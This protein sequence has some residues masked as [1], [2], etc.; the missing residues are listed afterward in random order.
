MDVAMMTMFNSEERH[1]QA[2]IRLGEASGLAFVKLWDFGESG[3]VEFRMA[4][5]SSSDGHQLKA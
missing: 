3:I 5:D 1:L 4:Q 2:Y